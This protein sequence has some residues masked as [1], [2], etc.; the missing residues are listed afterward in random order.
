M[1]KKTW[2]RVLAGDEIYNVT[3]APNK[4]YR[5]KTV[6]VS[7][8]QRG[9]G[10]EIIEFPGKYMNPYSGDTSF[11]F[12]SLENTYIRAFTTIDEAKDDYRLR[13]NDKIASLNR[14]IRNASDLI[15]EAQNKLRLAI[16]YDKYD[17]SKS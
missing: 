14:I 13:M 8:V 17:E 3:H 5:I 9:A 6:I 16:Y 11:T 12:N 7:S 1:N 10:F 4:L 15:S 2:N